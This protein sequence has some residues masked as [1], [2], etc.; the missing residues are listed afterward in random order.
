M[1]TYPLFTGVGDFLYL[2]SSVS[3]ADGEEEVFNKFI[4]YE[5]G[6]MEM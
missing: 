3:L 6:D 5:I 4:K 2:V 1:F